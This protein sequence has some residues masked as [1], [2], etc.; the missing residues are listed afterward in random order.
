MT[1]FEADFPRGTCPIHAFGPAGDAGAPIV[2]LFPDAFGP[3]PASFNLAEQVAGQGWRVLMPTPFY[4]H[5]PFAPI[6]PT[7]IFEAGPERDRLMGMFGSVSQENTD[8]DVAALLDLA[9]NRYGDEAPIA[10][11][12][13]CMGGRYAL[14]AICA[15]ARVRFAGAFH[16]GNIAPAEGDGPHRRFA[17]VNGRIYVGV[18]G[19][20][21]G[22]DAAEHGRLAEAL[23]TADT[24]HVIETYAGAAHGWVFPDIPIYDEAAAAKH[25]R[26]IVEHFGEMLG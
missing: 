5:L 12:G 10:A 9:G 18:A 3:R 11:L 15:S 23:R 17:A 21:P 4:E 26:R 6:T 24:D 7:S 1:M 25:M 14:T 16:S 13:Y 8:A 19:I 2:L 22:Y 20:D